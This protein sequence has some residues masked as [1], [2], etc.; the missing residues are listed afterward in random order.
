MTLLVVV[1][2]R[3]EAALLPAGVTVAIGTRALPA[4]VTA[5]LSF[6]IAGGLDPSTRPGDLIVASRVRAPSG[7]YAADADWAAALA[8]LTGARLGI[9]AG[10][11]AAVA[12][13]AAKRAL[14]A[15]TGALAVDM[16]SAAAAAHAAA[17]R[18]PFAV[19]RAIAD[20][21]DTAL[22]RAAL[23]GLR[24]DGGTAP[25]RVLAALARRPGELPALLRVARDARAAIDSLRRVAAH[26]TFPAGTPGA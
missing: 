4:G 18:L 19:L 22:P 10:A 1:G 15:G 12:T 21:H 9:L 26:V 13:P 3:A 5:V 7:A 8:R 20:P 11:T 2:M 24:P 14:H 25:W 6:G 17:H 16:E 23:V